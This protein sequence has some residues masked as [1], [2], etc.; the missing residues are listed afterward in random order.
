MLNEHLHT[1]FMKHPSVVKALPKIEKL[2]ADGKVPPTAAANQLI[3]I[4]RDGK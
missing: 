1:L 4:F 3:H 2:V